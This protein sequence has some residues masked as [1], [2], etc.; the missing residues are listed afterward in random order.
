MSNA[1][2]VG[3]STSTTDISSSELQRCSVGCEVMTKAVYLRARP[4][5][6][7]VLNQKSNC[8][9]KAVSA[10]MMRTQKKLL[11]RLKLN[12]LNWSCQGCLE[13]GVG[14]VCAGCDAQGINALVN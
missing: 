14:L 11:K 12:R 1:N 4:V 6:L 8:R 2:K 13:V 3:V 10:N 9:H 7:E 5:D